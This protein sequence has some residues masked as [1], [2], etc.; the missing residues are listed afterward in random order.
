MYQ[1]SLDKNFISAEGYSSYR[2][3]V[4]KVNILTFFIGLLAGFVILT[5]YFCKKFD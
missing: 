3:A 4:D 2:L 1:Y 5:L